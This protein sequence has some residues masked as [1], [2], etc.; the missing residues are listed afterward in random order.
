MLAKRSLEGKQEARERDR[1][2]KRRD[3]LTSDQLER[4]RSTD[5]NYK[6]KK[7]LNMTD[8]E[9]QKVRET[10]NSKYKPRNLKKRSNKE[11]LKEIKNI[12]KVIRM[13]KL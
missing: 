3:Q 7:R 11:H 10:R 13:R 2:R 1:E 5:R 12:E 6:R 8:T 4:V 9:K